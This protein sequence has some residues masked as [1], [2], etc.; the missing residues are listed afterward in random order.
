MNKA[1]LIDLISQAVQT[2]QGRTV[3]KTD[4]T[5]V[6]DS[7]SSVVNHAL[8]LDD[9]VTLPGIG[10]F[11]TQRKAARTGRNPR[12]GDAV[13]IAAKTVVKFVPAKSLDISLND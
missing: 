6:L 3:S 10:K 7:L 9:D 5:A 2:E 13:M 12:T 1:Q 4:V 11:K 8:K